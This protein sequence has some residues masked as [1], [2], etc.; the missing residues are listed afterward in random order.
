MVFSNRVG[1]FTTDAD[2][3]TL[4]PTDLDPR[5]WQALNEIKESE[6]VIASVTQ[7]K[8]RCENGVTGRQ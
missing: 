4:Y 6:N 8:K 1:T 3:E 2:G 5:I 7:K